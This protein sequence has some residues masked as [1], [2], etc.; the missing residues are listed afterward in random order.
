MGDE[1]GIEYVNSNFFEATENTFA[2]VI[3]RRHKWWILLVT[4]SELDG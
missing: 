4:E 2:L 1:L 3:P